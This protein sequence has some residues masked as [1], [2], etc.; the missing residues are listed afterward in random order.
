[1]AN[2]NTASIEGFDGMTAEQKVEALLKLNIP[3][4]V[5]MSKFVEKSVFD[6][7]ASEAAELSKQ[8]KAKMTD[9]EAKKAED[10]KALADLKNELES[11][12]KDKTIS[13]FTAKYIALGYDNDLAVDTA[14]AMAD[15]DMEK[16]F[17]NGETHKAA[18]E[19]K[20]KEDLMNNNPKPDGAGG[21]QKE[22]DAAVEKA[23]QIMQNRHGGDKEY[24][25][26][27]AKYRK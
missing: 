15:G 2:I 19:K 24:N 4:E 11:L 20:I 12:R 6:R 18:M 5:D 17:K 26:I 1:M 8:L 21:K 3:D 14:K 10:E 9:D 23:K 27:M 7:K 16:V 22:T 13:D 25:D